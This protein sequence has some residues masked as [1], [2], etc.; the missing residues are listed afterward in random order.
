MG[1]V[2]VKQQHDFQLKKQLSE[3]KTRTHTHTLH[4]VEISILCEAF[5]KST[6]NY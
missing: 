4:R 2:T 1:I 5:T 3:K 6:N